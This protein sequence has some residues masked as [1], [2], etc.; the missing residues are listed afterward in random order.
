[1]KKGAEDKCR[2]GKVVA[3]ERNVRLNDS[4]KTHR[5]KKP[6]EWNCKVKINNKELK[7]EKEFR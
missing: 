1:M 4:G 5:V 2:E 3:F 6:Y 7:E